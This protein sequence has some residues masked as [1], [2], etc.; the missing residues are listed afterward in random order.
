MT[1]PLIIREHNRAYIAAQVASAP[2]GWVVSIR[3]PT[4]TL[5][6]NARLWAMLTDLSRQK[7]GGIVATPEDWKCLAMHACGWESQFMQGIDGKPFPIGF[8]SSRL[9]VAQMRD[10]I[11]WLLAY[12]AEQGVVWSDPAM[13]RAA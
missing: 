6:Q 3:E 7:A 12:G 9:T 11:D 1:A 8:R 10:L 5:E 2:E 13:E 4:R